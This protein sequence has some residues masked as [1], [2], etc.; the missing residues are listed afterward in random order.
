M[1]EHLWFTDPSRVKLVDG[2]RV[3]LAVGRAPREIKRCEFPH[4]R[5][6]GSFLVGSPSTRSRSLAQ[7]HI[8]LS[9]FVSTDFVALSETTVLTSWWQSIRRRLVPGTIGARSQESATRLR[10]PLVGLQSHHLIAGLL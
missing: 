9:S 6:L 4:E 2:D 1:R 5:S 3:A 7:R 8:W 10:L